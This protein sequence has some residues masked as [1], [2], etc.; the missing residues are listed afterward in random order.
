[1]ERDGEGERAVLYS[2]AEREAPPVSVFVDTKVQRREERMEREKGGGMMVERRGRRSERIRP[3]TGGPRTLPT[4]THSECA[5]QPAI[6]INNS[7]LPC[8][9]AGF[10]L[11]VE[12][13]PLLPSR[14][15]RTTVSCHHFHCPRGGS[16]SGPGLPCR[17]PTPP[18]P[19]PLLSPSLSIFLYSCPSLSLWSQRERERMR[20]GLIELPFERSCVCVC[21]RLMTGCTLDTDVA[22]PSRRQL[23]FD[24]T[25]CRLIARQCLCEDSVTRS[26]VMR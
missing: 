12:P 3:R 14:K 25:T 26:Y 10:L 4:P 22:P 21:V 1:M 13:R 5:E 2:G 18:S 15:S 19:S 11:A 24:K 16:P 7:I 20:F 6:T 9:T 17:L 8:V 23:A